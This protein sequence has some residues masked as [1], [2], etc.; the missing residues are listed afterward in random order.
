M[1]KKPDN[2]KLSPN[3]VHSVNSVR[4]TSPPHPCYQCNPWLQFPASAPSVR[5]APSPFPHPPVHRNG[6]LMSFA[7]G[8]RRCVA[9]RSEAQT[10]ILSKGLSPFR[11]SRPLD[12]HSSAGATS[13][14]CKD[15]IRISLLSVPFVFFRGEYLSSRLRRS[16]EHMK[17]TS[18]RNIA[19]AYRGVPYYDNTG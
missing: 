3:S 1:R 12:R 11:P 19:P 8:A 15:P 18:L 2:P 6:D 9:S 17:D 10:L 4:K 13:G 16:S 14:S 5:G 7:P